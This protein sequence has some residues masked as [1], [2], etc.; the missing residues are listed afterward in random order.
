MVTDSL[1]T[2]VH[3]VWRRSNIMIRPGVA[4]VEIAVFEAKY[5]V[6]LPTSVR[7]YF[8]AAD[9][10]G[11]DMDEGLYR[12]WPLAEVQPVHDKLVSE[13]F[14][15]PDRYAY[16]DCFAFADHCINCWDYA[17][18]LT[19]DPEQPAPVFR[20]T[21]GDQTGELMASSFREFMTRY[22][23]NPDKII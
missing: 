23:D 7:D 14:S 20:V 16:P 9:G 1:W 22:A 19:K 12:F 21:G 4:C 18:R 17:V 11:D 8:S 2:C 13:R 10:T 6:V 15:Y 5:H 3:D